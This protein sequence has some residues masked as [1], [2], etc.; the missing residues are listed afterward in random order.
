MAAVRF[1]IGAIRAMTLGL[2]VLLLAAQ[3][4]AE[5]P[6]TVNGIILGTAEDFSTV[7]PAT[8]CLR[9]LVI[10]PKAGQT[11]QLTY[12]GIHHAT[13]RLI[14]ADGKYVD[15]TDGEI[16]KDQRRLNQPATWRRAGFEIYRLRGTRGKK[17]YQIEGVG[18]KTDDYSPP[19]IMVEGTAIA[20]SNG[21][22]DLFALVDVA[23]AASVLCDA[24]YAYGW[25]VILE[26]APVKIMPAGTP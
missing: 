25:D 26:G 14:L 17:S 7:G 21:D 19:R 13:L 18:R 23:D 10:R 16:F 5:P 8:V 9:E 4:A 2:S 11:V 6:R 3:S 1:L 24:R 22:L 12:S 15:F 20:G